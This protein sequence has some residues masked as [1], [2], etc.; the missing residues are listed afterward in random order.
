MAVRRCLWKAFKD[1]KEGKLALYRGL[2]PYQFV[3]FACGFAVWTEASPDGS[4][5]AVSELRK[6]PGG[7][8]I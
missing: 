3:S 4:L 1:I 5:I 6:H 2:Q 8:L 7:D